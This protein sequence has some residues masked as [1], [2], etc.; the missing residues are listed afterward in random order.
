LENFL[1]KKVDIASLVFF[2]I[3]FGILAFADICGQWFYYHLYEGYFKADAFHFHYY[4]FGW[5]NPL[6]EPWMSLVF[7]SLLV[8]AVLIVLGKWYHWAALYFALGFTYIFLCEKSLYLNHG[9]L[10]CHLCFFMALVPANRAFSWDVWSRPEIRLR[11]I[12]FW[13]IVILCFGMGVVYFYGG[14]AKLNA[15]WLQAIPVKYWLANKSD[16][17]LLGW[18]WEKEATAYFISWGGC[19][20]DL[21]ITFLLLNRRT[22]LWGLRFVVFFH[23]TNLILFK[24]GIFPWL[25]TAL[26]ALF[27]PPDFPRKVVAW[28][29]KR[30]SRVRR[31]RLGWYQAIKKRSRGVPAGILSYSPATR[32]LIFSLIILYGLFH[33]SYPFRHNLI[34]GQVVW[35]EEGHR[36]SWR[37][38]L[39]SKRGGG[40][41][42]LENPETGKK[43]TIHPED[44]LTY[45]QNRKIYG[46][47][48]MILEFAHYL[49]DHHKPEGWE[50]VEIYANI[51][52]SLNYRYHHK[53]IDSKID[54][55]KEQ[56]SP[57]RTSPWIQPFKDLGFPG[58]G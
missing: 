10:F 52:V 57:F 40:V 31:W 39:R 50:E 12:P 15:D 29:E 23:A 5:V 45:R 27:F 38:M 47:P 36:F 16:M 2:R 49:R 51:S 32:K 18:L 26:S 53:F 41:F 34:P 4:G 19:L 44:Y 22:R 58:D 30:I 35:T 6:P 7:A 54:L 43:K 13:P 1:F 33:L 8:A 14:L 28:L 21:S 3:V 46:H 42:F 37:M 48:D 9:Y 11:K 17:P 25:S 20:F 56:W 24:I 55:A